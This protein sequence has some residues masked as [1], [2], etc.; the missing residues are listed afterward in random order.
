MAHLAS[1]EP[2]APVAPPPLPEGR[3]GSLLGALG[4]AAGAR[5]KARSTPAGRPSHMWAEIELF[6]RRLVYFVWRIPN[7]IY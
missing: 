2:I 6:R 5:L 7:E 3:P 4:G 1:V